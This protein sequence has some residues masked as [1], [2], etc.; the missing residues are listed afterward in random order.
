[1]TSTLAL[2][3]AEVHQPHQIARETLV[4]AATGA[5]GRGVAL[6]SDASLE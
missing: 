2:Y 4:T 3:V 5:G 1:M 6:P